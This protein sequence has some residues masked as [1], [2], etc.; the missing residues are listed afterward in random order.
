M[1][2]EY[3]QGRGQFDTKKNLKEPFLVNEL[4]FV[5]RFFWDVNHC[6][7]E[8]CTFVDVQYQHDN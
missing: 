3:W 7:S 4:V 8:C 2:D 5:S 1:D 6:G